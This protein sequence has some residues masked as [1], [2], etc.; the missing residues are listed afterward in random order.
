MTRAGTGII[1]AESAADDLGVKV[2]DTVELSHPTRD[3]T[4]FVTTTD[5]GD[6]GRHPP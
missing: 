1:L 4:G 2:G 6:G 5:P 3:G